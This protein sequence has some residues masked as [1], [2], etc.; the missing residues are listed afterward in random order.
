[1]Y[2]TVYRMDLPDQITKEIKDDFKKTLKKRKK[3]KKKKKKKGKGKK[4]K[5]K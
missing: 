2:K 3:K 5:K 4:K 1:M